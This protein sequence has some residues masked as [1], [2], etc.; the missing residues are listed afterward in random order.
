MPTAKR[1]RDGIHS[2]WY[3]VRGRIFG[4]H[5]VPT[6]DTS[7][8][9]SSGCVVSGSVVN[10]SSM[11]F[12]KN[13]LI[14]YLCKVGSGYFIIT[15]NTSTTITVNGTPDQD[16]SSIIIYNLG[17]QIWYLR[18]PTYLTDSSEE[19]PGMDIDADIICLRAARDL[20]ST[21][22]KSEERVKSIININAMIE[23]KYRIRFQ[24][25]SAATGG[26][27]LILT[28]WNLRSDSGNY[29]EISGSTTDNNF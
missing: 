12:E 19:L 3:W 24:M 28:P 6:K 23:E 27:P 14:N 26:A 1:V 5:P 21:L 8:K 10:V 7:E 16:A 13:S 20:L 4:I 18:I 22:P 9:H 15:A 2:N 11:S 29:D 25:K 17:I